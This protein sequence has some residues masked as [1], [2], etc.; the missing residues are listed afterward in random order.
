VAAVLTRGEITTER[1]SP[2][3]AAALPP[4]LTSGTAP[5][6]VT[7]GMTDV[8]AETPCEIPHKRF[9]ENV[10]D[11]MAKSVATS[12]MILSAADAGVHD[13]RGGCINIRPGRLPDR[14]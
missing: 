4:S 3:G 7:S 6:S 13:E 12:R 10:T 2:L 11:E 14:E 8:S 5:Y 9:R 1:R